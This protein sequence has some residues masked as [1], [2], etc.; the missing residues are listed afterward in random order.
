MQADT[1]PT[2]ADEDTP[3]ESEQGWFGAGLKNDVADA[4]AEGY[5][6]ATAVAEECA[7]ASTMD[8]VNSP[9][10]AETLAAKGVASEPSEAL[11]EAASVG[12]LAVAEPEATPSEGIKQAIAM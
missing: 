3:F 4:T 12:E 1:A 2:E 8:A 5:A 6:M 11:A 7:M 10:L 9:A